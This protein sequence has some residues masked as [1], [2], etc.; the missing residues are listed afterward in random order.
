MDRLVEELDLYFS[1]KLKTFSVPLDPAAGTVFQRLVWDELTRIPYGETRTY[2]EIAEA[3]G[4]R[5]GARAVGLA[6]RSNWIPIV[7][8]CHRVIRANGSLGGYASG[9]DIKRRL[10]ELEGVKL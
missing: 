6:N 7:I 1:G 5:R 4:I 9:T 8:P 2:G 10:L 3:V